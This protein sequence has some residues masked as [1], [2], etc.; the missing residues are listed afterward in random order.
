M[1]KFYCVK[2]QNLEY[3]ENNLLYIVCKEYSDAWEELRRV[4]RELEVYNDVMDHTSEVV[5]LSNSE[6]R[7]ILENDEESVEF[8]YPLSK[9]SLDD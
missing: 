1:R 7:T 3:D 5:E 9:D 2:F 8:R 6:I 4:E